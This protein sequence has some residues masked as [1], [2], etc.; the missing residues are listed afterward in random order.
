MTFAGLSK[1]ED[2]ANVIAFLNS[3]SDAPQPIPAAPTEA[4]ATAAGTNADA[5]PG[6][7]TKGEGA[8][9]EPVVTE[10]QAGATKA[11]LKG[12]V[13]GEGAP[14]VAGTSAQTRK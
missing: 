11:G 2:R 9:K 3:K 12:T 4:P 8:A 13:G 5:K 14:S 6:A 7:N 10:A 1:P